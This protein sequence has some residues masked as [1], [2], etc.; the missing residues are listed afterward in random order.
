[1]TKNKF[2][3]FNTEAQILKTFNLNKLDEPSDLMKVWIDVT[4]ITLD[5]FEKK[6][7]NKIL[8]RAKNSID[9]WSEE[10]LKM[11]FIAYIVDLANLASTKEI[12]SLFDK[13]IEATVDNVHLKVKPDFTMAKGIMDLIESPYFHFHEYKKD[14]A[15]SRDPLGQL[16]KAFLIATEINKNA[17]PIYGAYIIG[18][19]WYFVVFQN[20]EY[21][22]SRA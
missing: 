8:L 11:Y 6:L 12:Q 2:L 22:V 15:S 5:D 20:R 1:M 10:D 14:K 4:I 18:R 19:F 13:Q 17:K 7:F 3:S 21:C 9:F 16:L